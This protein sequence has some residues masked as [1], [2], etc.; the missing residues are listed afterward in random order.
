MTIERTNDE[1][2]IRLPAYVNTEGLQ[3]LV[4]YLIY[5]E[6]TSKSMAEQSDID[7]LAKEV[8]AGWWSKNRNRLI[9]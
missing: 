9:K 1:I 4:D 6:S 2:I 7:L 5:K 8:K 3:R